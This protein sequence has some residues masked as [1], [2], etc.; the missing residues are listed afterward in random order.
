[1]DSL[2]PNPTPAAVPLP[3]PTPNPT[4]PAVDPKAANKAAPLFPNAPAQ[5]TRC[6]FTQPLHGLIDSSTLFQSGFQNANNLVLG[7]KMESTSLFTAREFTNDAQPILSTS[8][9]SKRKIEMLL[10][11][12]DVSEDLDPETEDVGYLNQFLL[13]FADY[14]IDQVIHRSCKIA[15]HCESTVLQPKDILLE[16]GTLH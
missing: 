16:L 5:S 7:Q 9:P 8:G 4:A 10:S 1:M 11:D 2:V 6:Y 15:K 14:F 3:T 12:L 13:Q